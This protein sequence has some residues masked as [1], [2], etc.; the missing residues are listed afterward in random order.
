MMDDAHGGKFTELRRLALEILDRCRQADP[1]TFISDLRELIVELDTNRV[2]LELQNEDLR[3]AQVE[4]EKL[5]RKYNELYQL[6]PIGYLTLSRDGRI[7]E[8]NTRAA[9]ML[10]L[11]RAE[12]GDLKLSAFVHFDDQ[13]TFHLHLQSLLESWRRQSCRLRLQN[14]AGTVLHVQLEGILR[15]DNDEIAGQILLAMADISELIE[16]REQLYALNEELELRVKRR[17]EKLEHTQS[18]LL[19]SEK[20]AAIGTLAA[21]IAHELNNPLQG[22]LNIIKGVGRRGVLEPE[23]AELMAIAV[24][25]CKRMRSLIQALQDF[26]RPTSGIRAPIDIHNALDSIILLYKKQFSTKNITV[27]KHYAVNLP[28]IYAVDDQLKQVIMNLLANAV[29]AC[30]NGGQITINTEADHSYLAFSIKDNGIGIDPAH[31][32]HIF[33]PFFSTKPEVKGTGLGLSVSYGIIKKHNGVIE[34]NSMPG[35]GTVFRIKLPLRN[36]DRG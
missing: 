33:E 14:R 16:A 10:D 21:S 20:L 26:N 13:D 25:E 12:L 8:T 15:V 29:D 32:H 36:P 4:L 5:H 6:A 31:K 7:V 11:N 27:D 9:H 30:K 23:D 34:V 35:K 22:V 19:H 1:V 18:Q 24:N 3:E 17:T 2:E 28:I